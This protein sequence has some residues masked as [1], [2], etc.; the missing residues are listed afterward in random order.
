MNLCPEGML[1]AVTLLFI[2]FILVGSYL[3]IFLL[4]FFIGARRPH[5]SRFYIE[6][7]HK[8]CLYTDRAFHSLVSLQHL[9]IWGLGP[10]PPVE[11]IAHELTVRRRKFS[12]RPSLS[13]LL[14]FL[15]LFFD[16]FLFRNGYNERE[17]G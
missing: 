11:A 1:I 12:Y 16:I 8:A 14:F 4:S 17:Q 6:R 15:F 13:L 7:I 10:K 3:I 2:I 5:L 9:A